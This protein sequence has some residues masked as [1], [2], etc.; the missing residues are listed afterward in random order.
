MVVILSIGFADLADSKKPGQKY[1]LLLS[2]TI[3]IGK[4]GSTV[5]TD[6]CTKLKDVVM[7]L[8]VSR[9]V[10]VSS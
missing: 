1:S 4:E 9:Q 10:K 3:K 5:L 2:D 6:G 7:E 8:D